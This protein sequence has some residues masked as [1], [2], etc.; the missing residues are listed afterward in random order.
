MER[1]APSWAPGDHP[2]TTR[3]GRTLRSSPHHQ[4]GGRWLESLAMLADPRSCRVPGLGGSAPF[5]RPHPWLLRCIA[6]GG[7]ASPP[8]P[9]QNGCIAH[10]LLGPLSTSPLRT[11]RGRPMWSGR[12][13]RPTWGVRGVPPRPR[14]HLGYAPSGHTDPPSG[15]PGTA[16]CG[17]VDPVDPHG[18]SGGCPPGRG[19]CMG[20]AAANITGRGVPP[21]HPHPTP[22]G[23]GG[24][25]PQTPPGTPPPGHP[26]DTPRDKN[27]APRAHFFG[28]LI[29]LPVGTKM[30]QI[31]GTKIR[32]GTD[33]VGQKWVRTAGTGLR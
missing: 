22:W 24:T 15:T 19:W 3:R 8:T 25:P 13:R 30:G 4:P 33:S 6:Q 32:P 23:L 20:Y 28:Y 21:G 12:P 2:H 7:W 31:F 14:V 29:T 5:A 18:G 1:E 16:P 27:P 26:R 9:A 11:P 10:A 17:P